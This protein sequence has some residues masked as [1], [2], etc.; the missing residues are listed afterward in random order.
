MSG[1]NDTNGNELLTF[2]TIASTTNFINIRGGTAAGGYPSLRSSGDDTNINL[3]FLA[4][5]T[6]AFLFQSSTTRAGNIAVQELVVNGGKY[7]GLQAPDAIAP[8]SSITLT[9]P[10]NS[11]GAANNIL[12]TDAGSTTAATLSWKSVTTLG[13]GIF[14]PLDSGLTALAAFNTNGIICQTANNTFSGRTVVTNA[15]NSITVTNPGGVAGNITVGLD[16]NSQTTLGTLLTSTLDPTLDYFT[17]YDASATTNKKVLANTI[18]KAGKNLLVAG[19]SNINPAS[20]GASVASLGI[21]AAVNEGNFGDFWKCVGV[22]TTARFTGFMANGSILGPTNTENPYI[23]LRH[24]LRV[25]CTTADASIAAG[26]FCG[27]R[28]MIPSKD[29]VACKWDNTLEG[30]PFTISFMVRSTI[31]GTYCICIQNSATGVISGAYYIA[32]YV[33]NASDTWEYKT[34]TVTAPPANTGTWDLSVNAAGIVIT[35][36]LLSG[37]DFNAGTAGT[38]TASVF[39]YSAATGFNYFPPDLATSGQVNS[40]SNTANNVAFGN[41]QVEEG[42]IATPYNQISAD[43]AA[44]YFGRYIESS[45]TEAIDP[46]LG[47]SPIYSTAVQV[48]TTTTRA[49]FPF[50]YKKFSIPV[51]TVWDDDGTAGSMSFTGTTGTVTDRTVTTVDT[52]HGFYVQQTAALDYFVTGSYRAVCNITGWNTV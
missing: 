24:Q 3:G 1:I 45:T 10:D 4:K 23:G 9:L 42:T 7:I 27:I 37:S 44:A 43:E 8:T 11:G 40:L 26:D 36:V 25:D 19:S 39:D 51:I 32:T 31:T 35:F 29:F 30:R 2:T 46:A 28:T 6:G 18:I 5:G 52:T 47:T 13:T 33:V 49:Y 16:I 15:D 38:W 48:G 21:T 41:I 50:K 17:A 12:V 20:Y 34:I 22:G 14:Q